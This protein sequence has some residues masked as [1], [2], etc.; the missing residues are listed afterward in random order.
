M[1]SDDTVMASAN[2]VQ[3]AKTL[4][5]VIANGLQDA[6]RQLDT[7]AGDILSSPAEWSGR[8]AKNFREN[9]W[10]PINTALGQTR[11]KLDELAAQVDQILADVMAAG[12]NA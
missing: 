2:A 1:P 10:P 4:K 12:G 3:A 6:L 5:T 7:Q 8:R 11:Q 9:V